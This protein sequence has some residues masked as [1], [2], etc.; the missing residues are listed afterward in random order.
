M[1]VPSFV[2]ISIGWMS[3]LLFILIYHKKYI[4]WWM[5]ALLVAGTLGNMIDRI[6]YGGVRDFINIGML[7]F[8]IFN[9]A[10]VLLT[11]GVLVW[12]GRVM[13]EKKK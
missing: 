9:I 3:L 6:I 4:S 2:S 8:P 7:D 5:T 1:K 11:I 12:I 10:D 13:L